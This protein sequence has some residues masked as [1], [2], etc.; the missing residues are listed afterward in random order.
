MEWQRPCSEG[1]AGF[2]CRVRLALLQGLSQLPGGASQADCLPPTEEGSLLSGFISCQLSVFF[3]CFCCSLRQTDGVGRPEKQD[4]QSGALPGE[5]TSTLGPGPSGSVP[6]PRPSLLLWSVPVLSPNLPTALCVQ[7]PQQPTPV[8]LARLHSWKHYTSVPWSSK[9]R[10]NSKPLGMTYELLRSP[11][12][13]DP[14]ILPQVPLPRMTAPVPISPF[15]TLCLISVYLA[16][17]TD[18][19]IGGANKSSWN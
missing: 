2:C 19:S 8:S 10:L 5:G 15:P 11:A 13:A 17:I 9:T 1:A 3:L 7:A 16:Q 12:S 14:P 6:L 18:S 4:L